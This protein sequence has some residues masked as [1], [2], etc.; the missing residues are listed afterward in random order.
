MVTER[1]SVFWASASKQVLGRRQ[2][3]LGSLVLSE[4]PLQL[5]DEMALPV[6]LQVGWGWG[7][8]LQNKL[9]D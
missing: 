3:R 9:L 2:R 7:L 8:Q 4:V 5:S 6:L 1:N